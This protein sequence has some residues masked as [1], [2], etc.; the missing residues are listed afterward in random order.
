MCPKIRCDGE[1]EK[2]YK[3]FLELNMA[4]LKVWS[5]LHTPIHAHTHRGNP[6]CCQSQALGDKA[7][8]RKDSTTVQ[9]KG[10]REIERLHASV[11]TKSSRLS[12]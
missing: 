3:I 10:E 4:P 7:Q 8:S 12:W 5:T 9:V 6:T 2:F 11:H 1:S